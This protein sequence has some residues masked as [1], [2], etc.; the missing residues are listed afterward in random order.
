MLG[1]LAHGLPQLL[2]PHGADQFMNAQALL[3]AGAGRRLLPEQIT[4][5]SVAN[6]VGALLGD[7]VYRAAARGIA[8]EIAAMPAP[9]Q[10][11]SKLE[12]LAA[13]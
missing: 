1:A 13:R 10:T 11:V 3:D 8:G 2:L 5:E 4:A 7:P 12:Q 9:A 6:A